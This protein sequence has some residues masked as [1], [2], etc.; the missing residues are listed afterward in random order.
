MYRRL[1]LLPHFSLR[2]FEG[3]SAAPNVAVPIRILREVLLVV[4][5]IEA[6]ISDVFAQ[7]YSPTLS[8]GRLPVDDVADTALDHGAIAYC[9]ARRYTIP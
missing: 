8:F 6:G 3:H 4:V 7:L 9:I 1:R 2:E 5:G